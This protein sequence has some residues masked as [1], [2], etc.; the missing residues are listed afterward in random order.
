MTKISV[1]YRINNCAVIRLLPNGIE[2]VICER[3]AERAMSDVAWQIAAL[4]AIRADVRRLARELRATRRL[5]R[6]GA[7][8]YRAHFRV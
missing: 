7:W 6:R 8:W 5:V 3:D 2:D 1:D 4:A